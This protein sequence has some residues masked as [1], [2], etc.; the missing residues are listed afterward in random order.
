MPPRRTGQAIGGSLLALAAGCAL[1][2]AVHD[3]APPAQQ[4]VIY[5]VMKGGTSGDRVVEPSLGDLSAYK[6]LPPL[7]TVDNP[8]TAVPSH[9]SAAPSL[10]MSCRCGQVS[11]F[12]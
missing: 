8:L 10:T 1:V 11:Y 2:Q 5:Q 4:P 12:S 9:G 6:V 3:S 7:V